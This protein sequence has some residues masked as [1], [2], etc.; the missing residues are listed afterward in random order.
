MTGEY[1]NEINEVFAKVREKEPVVHCITAS[2][3]TGIVADGLLAAEARPLMTETIAEAP[4]M[5]SI[6]DALMINLGTLS[7]EA[8]AAIPASVEVANSLKKPWVLDPTAVGVAPVRTPL[9]RRL[10]SYA[11]TIVRGN[12]SEIL[13]LAGQ[14]HA[15]RGADSTASPSDAHS[16][17]EDVIKRSG[18]VVTV[19]GDVDLVTGKERR[20]EVHRGTPILTR[21]TGTGCLLAALTAACAVVE[22]DA[23]IAAVAATTWL[24]GAGEMAEQVTTRPGSFRT[25]LLDALDGV[26][27]AS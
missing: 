22:D 12:A 11:P 20:T 6:A 19:T 23:F 18:G 5:T 1:R 4:T 17:A 9:A 15:G 21:V 24:T 8:L 27:D 26:T 13:A 16:A 10:L 2:V 25:A 14:Q 7:T 3:S